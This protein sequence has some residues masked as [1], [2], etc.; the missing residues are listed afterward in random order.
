MAHWSYLLAYSLN[1]EEIIFYIPFTDQIHDTMW[2]KIRE[3][4]AKHPIEIELYAEPS[5][6]LV[7]YTDWESRLKEGISIV[8]GGFN[9]HC[10]E[11]DW[12]LPTTLPAI[13]ASNS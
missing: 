10:F 12:E 9:C 2:K 5:E 11:E 4:K 1:I 3:F 8:E 13:K 7:E 6:R